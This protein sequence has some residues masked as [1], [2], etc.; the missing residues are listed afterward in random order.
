MSNIILDGLYQVEGINEQLADVKAKIEERINLNVYTDNIR[1]VVVPNTTVMRTCALVG[2][3]TQA[4]RNVKAILEQPIFYSKGQNHF[5]ASMFSK[6]FVKKAFVTLIKMRYSELDIDLNVPS[7]ISRI[8]AYEMLRGRDILM[9]EGAIEDWIYYQPKSNG[10]G[11]TL[12]IPRLEFVIGKY[13]NGNDAIIDMNS[14]SI[15]NTQIII[16]GATGSGKTNLLALLINQ[17]RKLSSD[18]M[19]P[20][21]FL[22]FDYKGEFSDTANASWLDLFDTDTTAILNP[23]DKPLPF[24]PFKDFAGKT[25]NEINLYATTMSHALCAIANAKISANMDDRLCQAIIN[26]YKSNEFH[27]ITFERILQN[28][29]SL[30]DDSSKVDSVVSSLNQIIRSHLF[31]D[32]DEIDLI[33]DCYII[34][35]GGYPKEGVIAKAIVYFVI[36]KLNNIYETLDKQLMN[37]DCVEIRHFTII[38]EAHYMLDF[39]NTPL[40]NLVQVGRNKGMSIILAT[41]NMS[42]YKSKYFDFY[43]NVQYPMIM[44]QQSQNDTIIK[45]LFGVTGNELNELKSEISRLE[46]GEVIMKD[47]ETALLGIG[48]KY[49]KIKLNKII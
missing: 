12:D 43:S 44:K 16:A 32:A 49:K 29:Q 37:D 6:P 34:N 13:E 2:L 3:S 46:K 8:L 14:R 5:P 25:I 9:K 11:G 45:D 35:L 26:A 10:S 22:L 17:M 4:E 15:A 24:T 30:L 38:D 33:K 1:P 41:Q 23:L 40:Q 39:E 20:V 36:S 19:H 18:S 48:K 31:S 27:S 28:Y 21:N 42:D 47:N 7:N